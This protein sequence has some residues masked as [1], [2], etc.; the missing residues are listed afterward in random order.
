VIALRT[1]PA[2]LLLVGSLLPAC[3]DDL[4]ALTITDLEAARRQAECTRFVRCGLFDD[5][6]NCTTFFRKTQDVSL[7]PSIDAGKLRFDPVAA[8]TCNRELANRSCDVTAA[9]ARE[10]PAVCKHVLIGT[11]PASQTCAADRECQTGRCDAKTCSRS[12]CCFGGC[13]AYVAPAALGAACDRTAGCVAGAFCTREGTC[14]ALSAADGACELDTDCVAGLGCVGATE[15]QSGTCRQLP[16]IGESCPYQRCAEIGARCDGSTC[17]AYGLAGAACT[18]SAECSEFRICDP[19][20]HR[21]VD[22]PTL[23][24]P[25]TESCRGEAWCDFAA[26]PVGIC[27]APSSNAAPCGASEEC[28]TRYCEEGPIFDQCASPAVCY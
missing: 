26:G 13:E 28:A 25:C 18:V 22:K 12:T 21:C 27:R 10:L 14:A 20:S 8:V 23:G 15:L 19:S 4:D 2:L 24:M 3:G 5:V 11:V 6:D 7:L 9:D 1:V 16:K 17:V